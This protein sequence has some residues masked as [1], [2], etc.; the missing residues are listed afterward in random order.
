ME[1]TLLSIF[2]GLIITFFV[3]FFPFVIV[4]TIN[5]FR[6]KPL[7]LKTAKIITI[8]VGIISYVVFTFLSIIKIISAV[9][10]APIIFWCYLGFRLITKDPQENIQNVENNGTQQDEFD[11]NGTNNKEAIKE[12]QEKQEYIISETDSEFSNSEKTINEYEYENSDD[13]TD[14]ERFAKY[15]QRKA[16]LLANEGIE[17]IPKTVPRNK[18]LSETITDNTECKIEATKNKFKIPFIV[19]SII[20]CIVSILS[21]VAIINQS[22]L[23]DEYKYRYEETEEKLEKSQEEIIKLGYSKDM[24]EDKIDKYENAFLFYDEHAACVD[25]NSSYYHK[26]DCMY[27]GDSSFWIYN[28]EAAKGRGYKPCPVCWKKDK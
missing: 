10:I 23:V 11:I 3:I 15:E 20:L 18:N 12:I 26:Y 14:E 6:M 19:V 8:V 25:E 1:N 2:L 22:K 5:E 27:L 13:L 16:E 28:T 9:S 7:K 24:L 17:Y 21:V 4:R